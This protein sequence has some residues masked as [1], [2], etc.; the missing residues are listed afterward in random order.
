MFKKCFKDSSTI[1]FVF[2]SQLLKHQIT[3][4][5]QLQVFALQARLEAGFLFYI[6]KTKVPNVFFA[7]SVWNVLSRFLPHL[8]RKIEPCGKN[9]HNLHHVFISGKQVIS[10]CVCQQD[11]PKIAEPIYIQIRG[12]VGHDPRKNP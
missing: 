1:F 10:L 11:F 8:T 12:G 4:I 6:R 3:N 9:T 5:N 7:A 2:P